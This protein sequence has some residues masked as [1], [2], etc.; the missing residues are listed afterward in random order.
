M[1]NWFFAEADAILKK[2]FSPQ[3]TGL[4]MEKCS[5]CIREKSWEFEHFRGFN[6]KI[7]SFYIV[8]SVVQ[9]K[10]KMDAAWSFGQTSVSGKEG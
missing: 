2:A 8:K 9:F 10:S 5:V 4:V 6:G 1:M 7:P 3:K